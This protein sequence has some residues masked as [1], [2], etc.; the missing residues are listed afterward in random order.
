M[1]QVPSRSDGFTKWL[2]V[3]TRENWKNCLEYGVWGASENRFK[4]LKQI[5][6]GDKVVVYIKP[7]K[8]AGIFEV[9]REYYYDD[10]EV[11]KDGLFPHRIGF[12]RPEKILHEPIDIRSM[13]NTLLKP[14][15]GSPRGYFGMGIRRLPE[16]EYKL[17]ESFID[18]N[19]ER[20]K[21]SE[22]SANK[23]NYF[24]LR[25][26]PDSEWHDIE[27]EEYHFGTNV[28]NNLKLVPGV[29]VVFDRN[30][31]GQTVFLG[32]ARIISIKE[33]EKGRR[34][35]KGRTIVHKIAYLGEYEKFDPP[36][37][38]N[39]SI[40]EM[41]ESVPGYNFEHAIRRITKEIYKSILE[42][43]GS[44]SGQESHSDEKRIVLE[45]ISNSKLNISSVC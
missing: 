8:I 16:T 33:E 11:W 4:G 7:M 20:A 32:R 10:S 29:N 24:V 3:T 31:N 14:K 43:Y 25:T 19:L 6:V 30:I 22:S 40:R 26:K 45:R 41:M 23:A 34:S 27:G 9:S 5:R 42:K 15:K 17:F 36:L 35:P 2:G 37:P 39:S 18:E 12:I 21:E 1:T 38:R 28:P 44:D 13:Y